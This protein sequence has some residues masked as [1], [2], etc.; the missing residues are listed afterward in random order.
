MLEV[1]AISKRYGETVALSEA[2]IGFRAGTIHTILG[3]NGSGKST[4]V[5]LLSGIVQPD[6]G[7]I[8]LDGKPFSGR[9][10]ATFQAAGFATVFQEVLIAPDRSV[11]DNILL[12]LDGLLRRNVP[13]GER[14]ARAQAVLSR[15]ARTHV[16][17][18]APAGQL[19]LAA[20]QLVVLARAVVRNPRILI[21]DEVTAALDFADREAVFSLMRALAGQGTLI[22]FITHRMDEVMA[23]SDRISILR[24]GKVVRTE[25]RGA[26]TP[27]ELLKAMAPQT[28]AELAHA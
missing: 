19:P 20:Q 27:A 2:S 16:P 12:G 4:L 13:R 28:A 1:R 23:L 22:L 24:G 6:A 7:K 25:E 5:K 11:T 14:K 10:P 8:L 21:L 26:S 15:F 17:L 3:E 18:D 9:G